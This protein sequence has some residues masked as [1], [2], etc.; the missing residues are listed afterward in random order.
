MK[1]LLAFLSVVFLLV[2][3]GCNSDKKDSSDTGHSAHMNVIT[4]KI[5]EIKDNN[6]IL[7]QITKERGGYKVDDKILIKYEK[8][9]E[10]NGNDPDGKQTE[11]T[12]VLNDEVS[13]QFWPDE[14]NKKDGYDYIQVRSVNK[15]I[16]QSDNK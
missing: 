13:T 4:G 7:L 6:T 5:I 16:P 9:Y 12:P 10:I 1:K 3:V 2:C 8:I 14:V 11:I 15:H